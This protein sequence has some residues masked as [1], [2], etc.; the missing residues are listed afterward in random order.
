MAALPLSRYGTWPTVNFGSG[1]HFGIAL[2][3]L[4]Y[5]VRYLYHYALATF[6]GVLIMIIYYFL[7]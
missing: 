4:I 7:R 6:V 5:I 1:R 3:Y 2:T